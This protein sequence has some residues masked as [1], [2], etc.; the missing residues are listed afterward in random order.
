MKNIIH[1]MLCFALLAFCTGY[2]GAQGPEIRKVIPAKQGGRTVPAEVM[3]DIYEIVK[4]PFK[5]GVVLKGASSGQKVDSPGIFK[6]GDHWYMTYVT[7][8]GAGYESAIAVSDDMLTWT[9]LGKTLPFRQ[10]TWDACQAGGYLALQDHNWGGSYE[11]GKYDG[12]Y[13]MSYLGGKLKGYEADPLMVGMAYTNDPTTSQPW[14]RLAEPVL[15]R[16]QADCRPWEALTQYKSNIIHDNAETLG[17]PFVMY[18]N[19]KTKSSYEVIGMAVSKDMK[20]WL[21]YGDKPVL[22]HGK[23]LTADPQISKIGELWVMFYFG[24]IYQPPIGEGGAF[25][26]FACSYD[27]VNWTDWQGAN[28]VESSEP[29]DK[30]C[31]HKPWVVV[32]EGIVYHYYN[33]VGD[34]GRVI[35]LATSKDLRPTRIG[36][37]NSMPN[38]S[39]DESDEKRVAGP[40][41][42]E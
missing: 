36:N 11:L 9:P 27:L 21:R 32:H 30:T 4:T 34:Q 22:D 13:W 35:A 33:A 19:A 42:R 15:T 17:Y 25:E 31:A 5:Y 3:N 20:T 10:G 29:W 8:E 38:K 18:Y 1:W 28:L 7:F 24:A 2:S 41:Q 6:H 12:K 16:D 23:G 39:A 26:R 37:S 14:I 40:P